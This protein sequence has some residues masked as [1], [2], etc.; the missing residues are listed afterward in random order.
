MTYD[1]SE[2]PRE[3]QGVCELFDLLFKFGELRG[4]RTSAPMMMDDPMGLAAHGYGCAQ[5]GPIRYA[6]LASL[7]S[8]IPILA[9]QVEVVD[10]PGALE[11][12][13]KYCGL[14]MTEED[15]SLPSNVILSVVNHCTVSEQD[16]PVHGAMPLASMSLQRDDTIG[17][18]FVSRH[19][20]CP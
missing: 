17:G 12:F 8:V 2:S 4:N 20:A 14:S 19:H 9:L 3:L 10:S 13:L 18:D 5:N 11:D 15:K 16:N 7:R 6:G 1:P